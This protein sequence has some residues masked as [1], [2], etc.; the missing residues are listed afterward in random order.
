MATTLVLG[1][2]YA[3]M[4]AIKFLQKTLPNDDQLILVDQTPIH[5]EKTNLHEVAAGTIDP[6]RITYNI[7]SIIAKRVQ[8][9][10]ATVNNVDVDQKQVAFDD[11]ETI[12][13]DYLVLA[14][15]FQSETFGVP[16]A[17]E[18]A[19]P[20]DDL[21][22]SKA[23]YQHIEARIKAYAQTKD[24]N[25]LK[26]AVCGAGFTGIEL[27]GELTQS[28]PKL[29]AKY[30]T[31]AIKLV[32]LERM[33]SILPMFI[34]DLRDYAL[35]FLEK[36]NVEMRLGASIEAIKPGAVVYSD[37]AKQQHEFTANTIIWTVG[38]SGSHVIADSG[39]EQRRNRVVVQPDLSLDNHPEVFIVGDV[40]AVMDASS[41]RPYPTTAQIALA[42]G[43]QAAKNIAA[44]RQG[45]M[46]TP[47][48]YQ[49]SGTV[50]S[51]SDRDAIGE[52]FSSNRPVHG[53]PASALKKIITDRSLL[54]S[55]HLGTVFSK[56]RFDLYH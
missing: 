32:C 37:D 41:N 36:N 54:E 23:V 28:L 40:A 53:Y 30:Q 31:P 15:G 7:P 25:D 42:A 8:F 20:M 47:F 5:T 48:N 14:L 4:R 34:Q 13:Y 27:L 56:G 21:E 19:L 12:S 38:V 55:A 39:F 29:A 18:N 6:D 35:K 10:Q 51:L 9:V 2:G 17:D 45:Q 33:P 44:S 24:R 3:G 11:H 26:V 50:A 43:E 22:T 49:S 46:T 16:G 1:G 52:I